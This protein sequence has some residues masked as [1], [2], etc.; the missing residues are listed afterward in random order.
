VNFDS[1]A[2]TSTDR[3]AVVVLGQRDGHSPVFLR[4]LSIESGTTLADAREAR[5]LTCNHSVTP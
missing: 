3:S 2:D 5:C 4:T 1:V